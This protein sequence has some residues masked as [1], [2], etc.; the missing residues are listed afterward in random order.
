MSRA[1][2]YQ[3][4]QRIGAVGLRA[5]PSCECYFADGVCPLCGKACPPELLE[6]SFAGSGKLR[7]RKSNKYIPVCFAWWVLIP[8]II[9]APLVGF[10]LLIISPYTVKTKVVT[11]A[12]YLT[13]GFLLMVIMFL[14]E[15]N[16]GGIRDLLLPLGGSAASAW[17]PRAEDF[18]PLF[19]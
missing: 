14:I 8:L 5:C 16:V 17:L 13:V 18:S 9:F 15:L 12:V 3:D 11:V 19:R 10:V 1:S 7:Q 6:E 2:D 4:S